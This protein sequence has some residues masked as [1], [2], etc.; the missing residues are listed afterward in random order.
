MQAEEFVREGAYTQARLA[1]EAVLRRGAG[2]A[3]AEARVWCVGPRPPFWDAN[4]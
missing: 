3:A 1:L 2:D 4:L